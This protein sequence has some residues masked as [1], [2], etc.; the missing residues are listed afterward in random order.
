MTA[1][2]RQGKGEGKEGKV[3]RSSFCVGRERK[4][5]EKRERSETQ[6]GEEGQRSDGREALC[7]TVW[8]P[9]DWQRCGL[10]ICLLWVLR[11]K[12]NRCWHWEGYFTVPTRRK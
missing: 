1:K 12:T 7:P 8:D 9:S 10:L 11:Q 4:D 6:E 2:H 3:N 5:E